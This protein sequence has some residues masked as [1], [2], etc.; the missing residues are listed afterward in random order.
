MNVK[1]EYD[2]IMKNVYNTSIE[3][4]DF[5]N[6]EQASNVINS[7]V[8]NVT[9]GLIPTL[10]KQGRQF[11]AVHP[12]GLSIILAITC[13]FYHYRKHSKRHDASPT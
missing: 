9:H 12:P 11:T 6:P 2:T 1:E 4:L 13:S 7:W 8:N 10:V 5:S 3:T